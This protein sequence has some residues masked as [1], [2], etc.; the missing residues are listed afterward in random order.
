MNI[1]K[2]QFRLLV[3]IQFFLGI[4]S[5]VSS[6]MGQSSLPI[7]LQNYLDQYFSKSPSIIEW[8]LLVISVIAIISNIAL[9]FF[10]QWSKN[11]FSISYIITCAGMVF[12]GPV[13]QTSLEVAFSELSIFC[14][15]I[16]VACMYL[17]NVREYYFIKPA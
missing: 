9:L 2:S 16:I 4:A 8:I 7:E 10:A 12:S 13:I 15:G 3:A 5:L 14:T 1:S 17:T 11:I 6:F